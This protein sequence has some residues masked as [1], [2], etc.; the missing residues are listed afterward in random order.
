MKTQDEKGYVLVGVLFIMAIGLFISGR[1][2]ENTSTGLKTRALVKTQA[3]YQY[4]C[5][6]T[7]NRVVAWLQDNSKNIVTA[8]TG[9][10]FENNFDMSSP[11]EGDNDGE[12]FQVP[13]MVKMAGTN[14][15]VLLSNNS[16]FGTAAFPATTNIDTN[17]AFDAAASFQ[18]ANLGS[19]NARAVLMWARATDGNYEPIFRVDAVTGNNPDRGAHMYTYVTSQLVVDAD[20]GGGG[21]PTGIGFY[22]ETGALETQTGNNQCYSYMWTHDGTSWSKGAPRSNCVVAS[23]STISLK[24][25]INGNALSTTNNGVTLVA[26]TGA[27]SGTVC[28]TAG[29]HNYTLNAFQNWTDTCAASSQGNLTI[30]GATSLASGPALANQCWETV[31]IDNNST[32][33]LTDKDNPYRFKTLV[34]QNNSNSRLAL[35]NMVAGEKVTIYAD[36]FAGGSVNGNQLFNTNNSPQN[37]LVNI[38]GTADVLLNGTAVIQAH[39]VAP[40]VAM[41]LNGNF[42]F[43]GAIEASSMNVLGNSKFNYDENI[44]LEGVSP[45]ELSDIA[46]TIKKASQRYR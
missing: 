44:I 30:T 37:L 23:K 45:P 24:S 25:S 3:Q 4:E 31:T 2:L 42:N 12:H 5:E 41:T 43:H 34:F 16:F 8:F 15:S 11:T 35:V 33:T 26:P 27:V 20:A 9:T 22:T 13:T 38:T 40:L 29:C 6:E 18:S 39:I 19:A 32:L 1:M 46:F 28:E 14:D 10:N 17:V 36:D 21:G 7:L